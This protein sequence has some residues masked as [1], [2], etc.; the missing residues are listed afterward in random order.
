MIVSNIFTLVYF[1]SQFS[2]TFCNFISNIQIKMHN[3]IDFDYYLTFK[4]AKLFSRYKSI[5][6]KLTTQMNV[7]LKKNFGYK[8]KYYFGMAQQL[9][10]FKHKYYKNYRS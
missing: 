1:Q 2:Y 6:R 7:Y 9:T 5:H 4:H 8:I 10:L 3:N